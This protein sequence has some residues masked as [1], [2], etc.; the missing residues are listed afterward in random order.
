MMNSEFLDGVL[1]RRRAALK[2]L[3]AL[4]AAAVTP[5]ALAKKSEDVERFDYSDPYDNVYAFGKVWAGYGAPQ[6][7]AYHGIMYGRAG[8]K[9]H[10][11]LFGYTGTGVMQAR[12]N[13]DRSVSIRGKETGF[14]TDLATGDILEEWLNPY[15]GERVKPFNFL[16]EV[17]ATLTAEMPKYAFGKPDDEPTLMNKGSLQAGADTIPFLLPF[18]NYGDDLLFT[19]DYA[20][21]YTNPV[22]R[23]KWPKASTGVKISPSEHFTFRVSKSELEDRSIPSSR[24]VAGFTRVSEWWP[25]MK[26][27]GHKYQDGIIFGRMHSHKGLPGYQDLPPR[28]LAYLEKNYPEYLEVPADWNPRK[29]AGTWEKYA[30]EV[31]PEV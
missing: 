22:T 29:P 18:E 28:L 10:K 25:W 2:A 3:A 15:T 11:P 24:F 4:S 5:A 27:G 21:G 1:L 12:I 9:R 8:G 13:S 19:W 16:N 14:F 20:H 6:Y 26:M 23:E 30:A 7:G 31:A 17:G